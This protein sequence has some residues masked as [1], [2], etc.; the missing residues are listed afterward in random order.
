MLKLESKNVFDHLKMIQNQNKQD[1][2]WWE[3]FIK[4]EKIV[5]MVMFNGLLDCYEIFIQTISSE[6][7]GMGIV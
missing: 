5:K 6:V 2:L 7:L 3:E 1:W 4:N